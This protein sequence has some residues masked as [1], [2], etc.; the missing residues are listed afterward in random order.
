MIPERGLENPF[1][2]VKRGGREGRILDDGHPC[3]PFGKN[4]GIESVFKIRAYGFII[5]GS[6]TMQGPEA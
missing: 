4:E 3:R 2:L 5:I 6:K 1:A